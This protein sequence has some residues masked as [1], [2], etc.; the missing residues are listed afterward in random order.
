MKPS[1]LLGAWNFVGCTR[2]TEGAAPDQP[3][4]PHPTGLI[5][6]TPDGMM[7]AFIQRDPALPGD[8]SPLAAYA[9]RWEMEGDMVRHHVRFNTEADR[10]GQTLIRRARFEGKT[11]VLQTEKKTGKRGLSW[12][13]F[14]WARP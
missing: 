6:Y 1:D 12:M 8:G 9:G 7:A 11:L 14:S 10:A 13:D 3:L 5:L 4:G 2:Y